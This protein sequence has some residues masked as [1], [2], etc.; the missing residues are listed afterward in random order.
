MV[1]KFN[2]IGE[3]VC[4]SCGSEYLHHHKVEVFERKEDATQGLHVTV[5][6][7]S[8]AIDNVLDGNPSARRHGLSVHFWCEGC[9]AEPVLSIGQHKGN[10]NV[11][12]K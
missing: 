2:G 6:K 4:P 11:T 12:F 10:T 8:A 9:K 1:P 5:S 7:D 3:L